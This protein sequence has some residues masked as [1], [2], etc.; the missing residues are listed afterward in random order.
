MV[1]PLEALGALE[2]NPCNDFALDCVRLSLED[3]ERLKELWRLHCRGMLSL[4]GKFEADRI[5]KE[6]EG[7]GDT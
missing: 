1:T 2:D 5:C 7:K 3:F 4:D 6:S